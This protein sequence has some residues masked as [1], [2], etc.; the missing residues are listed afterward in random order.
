MA[1]L[2]D[3]LTVKTSTLPGAGKGLFTKQPIK[4]GERIVEYTGNV[5]T[6]KEAQKDV[7]N[8]Y[9]FFINN[10]RVIDAKHDE[11]SIARYANDARGL[12]RVKGMKN[13]A[14]YVIEK[15]RVYIEAIADIPKG[16]EI[17]VS[18]SKEYWDVLRQNIKADKEN[19]KA[20]KK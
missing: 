16:A 10:K 7:D 19:A 8:G 15:G 3:Q 14:E 4:K 11:S 9:I 17:F 6:W 20:G 12:K 1:L 13:N 18:Y 2:E 5:I